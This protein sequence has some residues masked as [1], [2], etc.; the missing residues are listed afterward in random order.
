MHFFNLHLLFF[1]KAGYNT[2]MEYLQSLVNEYKPGLSSYPTKVGILGGTFNP[3]H[4]GHIDLAVKVHQEF[5]LSRVLLLMSGNPPHKTPSELAP[6]HH[7]LN[8]LELA[9]KKHPFLEISHLET[10]RSGIIYT[11]DTLG[12]LSREQ[13]DNEFYYIIGSD[14]LFELES[15]KNIEQ[16]FCLTYFICMKRPGNSFLQIIMEVERLN[17]I[18]GNKIKLS[19]YAGIPIS[20]SEIRDAIAKR[21]HPVENLPEE[22]EAYIEQ[23]ELYR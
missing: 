18:Y 6:A 2:D 16:V 9:A 23:Y 11:V 12:Q 14:T 7:R 10:S 17:S 4:T 20:S 21:R 19:N 13:P 22:V 3:V 1:K 15:W 8:M 5:N